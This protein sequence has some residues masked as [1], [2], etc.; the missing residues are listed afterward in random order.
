MYSETGT[1]DQATVITDL[2]SSL[3]GEPVTVSVPSDCIRI[4][5]AYYVDNDVS[6]KEKYNAFLD[7]LVWTPD[8]SPAV[9]EV[10]PEDDS[11]TVEEGQT[12]CFM[13][14]GYDITGFLNIPDPVNGVI[15]LTQVTVK[16][17]IVQEILDPASGAVLKLDSEAPSIKTAPTRAGLTYVLY[18]GATLDG[19]SPGA[20]TIGDGN[21]WAP[22]IT[23]KG[24]ASAFYMIKVTQRHE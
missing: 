4:G 13:K 6:G 12:L 14:D 7:H 17:E 15:D 5:F 16:D 3:S 18:E 10:G 19:M 20:K 11:V 8:E 24:G 9:V 22:A 23:V 2:K 1:N 21:P